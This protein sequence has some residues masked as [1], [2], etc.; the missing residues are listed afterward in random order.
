MTAI[1][2]TNVTT[3][4]GFLGTANTT[5]QGWFWTGMAWMMFIIILITFL[6]FGFEVAILAAAFITLLASILL[7]YMGLISAWTV[8]TFVGIILSMFLY[9]IWSSNRN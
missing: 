6:G 5:T 7:L 4:E 3:F 2:W 1:N 8:G 9:L